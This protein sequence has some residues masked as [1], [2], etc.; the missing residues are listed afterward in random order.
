MLIK[1][2][3]LLSLA[4]LATLVNSNGIRVWQERGVLMID[5]KNFAKV[6]A[7]TP[8]LVLDFSTDWW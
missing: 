1:N 6:A 8:Y 7:E 2:F 5:D 3:T 4:L